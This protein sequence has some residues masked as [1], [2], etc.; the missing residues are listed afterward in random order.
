MS[1]QQRCQNLALL[2]HSHD[3]NTVSYMYLTKDVIFSVGLWNT[4][5]NAQQIW[6]SCDWITPAMMIQVQQLQYYHANEILWL[7]RTNKQPWVPH[8]SSQSTCTFAPN[9]TQDKF[10]VC[11]SNGYNA[12][13]LRRLNKHRNTCHDSQQL[14][15]YKKHFLV[16]WH[17][18]T[19]MHTQTDRQTPNNNNSFHYHS[20]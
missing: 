15:Y 8:P 19:G 20:W 10:H 7:N 18:Q 17:T 2:S 6:S 4:F 5:K 16:C 11:I 13:V 3:N 9:Y 14:A 12:I 1:A